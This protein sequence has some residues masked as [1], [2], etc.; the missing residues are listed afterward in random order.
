MEKKQKCRCEERPKPNPPA[1]AQPVRQLLLE[2]AGQASAGSLSRE[3]DR[4]KL[5]EGSAARR[6]CAHLHT[7]QIKRFLS[8]CREKE[9]TKLTSGF[10]TARIN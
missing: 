6:H 5:P 7:A 2:A 8:V 9:Y 1:R 4:K 3:A 10:F